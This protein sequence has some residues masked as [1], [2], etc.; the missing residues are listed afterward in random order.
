[1]ERFHLLDDFWRTWQA[2]FTELE[3]THTSLGR[4][5]LLPVTGRA[6][7]VGDR[8][9]RG[10]RRGVAAPGRGRPAVRPRG[11]DLR[12]RRVLRAAC[13][14][15]TTSA[16][17]TTPTRSPVIRSASPRT[18]SSRRATQLVE[19]GIPVRADRDAAWFDFTGWRVNYDVP[20][21]GLAG[22]VMV[23]YA[24]WSSDRSLRY[25]RP[26]CARSAPRPIGAGS[27][28]RSRSSC[29]AGVSSRRMNHSVPKAR[30]KASAGEGEEE[31][32][33]GDLLRVRRHRRPLAVEHGGDVD[34]GGDPGLGDAEVDLLGVG[35]ARRRP[36]T[37]SPQARPA[38][39]GSAPCS[40]SP[41]RRGACPRARRRADRRRAPGCGRGGRSRRA[42]RRW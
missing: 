11:R 28:R 10:A 14:S 7:L 9:R 2:W 41:R 42:R 35:R 27:A 30:P 20:L 39:R 6:P 3:E 29:S 5:Q 15:P 4:A 37:A 18:S 22:F 40:P 13:R 25:R 26:R 31:G 38:A 17:R 34:G 21:L 23:P 12:A 32:L 33:G 8:E 24:P 16:S 19:A 1:M 36:G